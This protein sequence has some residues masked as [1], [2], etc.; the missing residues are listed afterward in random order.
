LSIPSCIE[1]IEPILRFLVRTP[2]GTKARDA[3][4]EA[5]IVL[6]LSEADRRERLPSGVQPIYKNRAGWA[7]DRLKRA[8]LSSSPRHGFW[9]LTEK[10]IAYAAD[11]PAPLRADYSAHV[12]AVAII[13]LWVEVRRRGNRE[14]SPRIRL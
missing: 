6:G 8:G 7:H 12:N 5:A 10:G 2:E 14:V 11:H 13:P 4:E 1:F 9:K 3:H